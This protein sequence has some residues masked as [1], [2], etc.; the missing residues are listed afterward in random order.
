MGQG[1]FPISNALVTLNCGTPQP[2]N[3]EGIFSFEQQRPGSHLITVTHDLYVS[4]ENVFELTTTDK[5]IEFSLVFKQFNIDIVVSDGVSGALIYNVIVELTPSSSNSITQSTNNDGFVQFEDVVIDHYSVTSTHSLYHDK[6]F[7]LEFVNK[8]SAFYVKLEPILPKI[9]VNIKGP[10]NFPISNALVTLNCGTPRSTNLEGIFSFEQQRPGSYLITVTHDLYVSQENVFELTTTDKSIEFSLVFKQFNIDI[11]VSDGVS[12]AL[13]ENVIVELTPSSSNSI[14]QSTNN[15][16]FVQFEDVVIDH[17]SVALTHSLYHDKEFELEFVNKNSTFYIKLEPILPKI[18]VNIMGQGNFP[19]SNALV[20]LNCGTPQPTNL[21]GFFSFEQQRPGSHLITVTHDLYV[22]QEN[23]FEL[24]TTDK[25]IEFS[26]VFK[27]FNID[28]VVSDGVSGALIDNVIVE[29]TPSSSNSITQLTNNDGFVQFEDV[30]IDH[31]SVTLTHSLYH[32]KEFELEFVNKNSAFYLKLEPILPKITVNIMGQGNFPISNAL[33]TLNCGPPQPTNL[34]GIFSFEQQRPGSHLI[35]VTH[36]LYVSQENVFELT[37]TDKSIEF[38]LV[39][40]QFNIDVVV[41]DG[42]SGA[43]IDNVIVELTP[44]S[45]NSITQLTNNDGFVQFEDVVIDHYFVT[46]THSLY[47]DKEFELEFVNKNSTF[48]LKLE[49]ILPKITV[50]IKGPDNFPISNALVTLNC[51]TPQPTNLE[52]IFSFEQQRPGSYFITVTHDLYVSQ[53]NVFEL[54]TTDKSIEFSLVFKQFNIDIVVSDGVSGA[55]IDNVIVELTPSSSNSI[56][57]STNNDGFV[58]FEDVVIDHYSVT[59]THSLYHDKEFELEFVNKNSAFYV[60]LEPILPKITVN[61]KGQGNFPISNALVTLNCGPP[62]P[63]N[64]EGIFSFEQQRPGSH[65]I[66]VTHDLYVSQENVFELTTTDKSIE[67]SLVFK[68]FNIDIVVSDGV[69]GALIDNVIVELTPS[70]SN[71][72]TQLTNNDGFVQFE[73]VVIDHY[74][75]TL[76]HSL[77]HDKEFEL[78]FV[79]KNSAFYLKLEPVLPKITVNIMGQGNFPISNALVTLNCGP[80]QPTNLEGIFSFE[81]QRPGFH[82]IT[83]T[84]DLYVSQENVFELTTT[85]KSIEFSLVFKQFNIDV[86]VSDGVSG[87]LIDNVIVELTPSSSNSI[88]QLTNSDGFVQFEDVVIDHYSVTLTHSL[89]HD[90]EFELEFVNKNSAF[91]LKL[92][93]IFTSLTVSIVDEDEL[94][95]SSVSV[96]L[97]NNSP[98]LS[99]S[100]GQVLFSNIR[101]GNYL[102]S[103]THDNFEP[104][105]ADLFIHISPKSLTVTMSWKFL[106]F[107]FIILENYSVVPNVDCTI[108][109]VSLQGQTVSFSLQTNAFG[110]LSVQLPSY[111][112]DVVLEI[113]EYE[114]VSVEELS[115]VSVV[116]VSRIPD[117]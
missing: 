94:P 5:S 85:D 69:S 57:Q 63:T 95:I 96:T 109:Y 38:S 92:E 50:N 56:T 82:L 42:V 48:F 65:L 46:L 7:E 28:I 100:S 51:G 54:T 23:V 31:Y 78:E 107:N 14:T 74:S 47:H 24:T 90:K 13:I 101:P 44:S 20:T 33:V 64:L 91:Y 83:V 88:T 37:T 84:H 99:D 87:A 97:N 11:V 70:S 113:F 12:G 35:T 8:N 81:Q 17:Y 59:L 111:V 110:I 116:N 49:P 29:L 34:E 79:N 2:T 18:T 26:L 52:G 93:P 21:E 114:P 75:V 4:Q 16:G 104:V 3:L 71:S 53:E 77:Y 73:D 40:K 66:T 106:E 22:S 80:P 43:L 19:I 98:V 6:E 102:L 103:V 30:V 32:D 25:S 68:Q 41:S 61:I 36:D 89:Y 58:Q 45:S 115:V 112:S 10:D 1:N 76:T 86:V 108:S 105:L 62:Q 117:D 27:Q 9:T 55:L 72:I 39:F 60:K 15:D 67:F